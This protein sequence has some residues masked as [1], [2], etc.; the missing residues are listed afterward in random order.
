ME[1]GDTEMERGGGT[2]G[3]GEIQMERGGNRW[4]QGDTEMERKYGDGERLKER[5][6]K[7]EKELEMKR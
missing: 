4:R 1:M 2:D 6:R 3:D 7:V 5:D